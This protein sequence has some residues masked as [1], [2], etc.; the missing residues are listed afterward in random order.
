MRSLLTYWRGG[1]AASASNLGDSPSKRAKLAT[2]KQKLGYAPP[3]TYAHLNHLQDHMKLDLDILFCGIN[4]GKMSATVGH[5]FAHPTNQFYRALHASGLTDKLLDPSEDVAM[6]ERYNY[7]LTNIVARPSVSATEL[8]RAEKVAG[9]P[10]LLAKISRV[11]PRIVCFIGR[12]IADAVETAIR[13]HRRRS[14]R[15]KKAVGETGVL[16]TLKGRGTSPIAGPPEDLLL[17]PK[18]PNYVSPLAA[19]ARGFRLMSYKMV[20]LLTAEDMVPKSVKETLFF[21]APSTSGR[22]TNYRLEDR[23]QIFRLLGKERDAA[24]ADTTDT[25]HFDVIPPSLYC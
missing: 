25:A 19:T 15:R 10:D 14:G 4:P 2:P 18:D 21:T 8:T 7:G 20:H 13:Q 5:H 24:I 1:R 6:P 17:D 23:I 16:P 3:E 11:R 9:V 22:V 12:E